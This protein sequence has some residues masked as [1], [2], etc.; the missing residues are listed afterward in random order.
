MSAEMLV[1]GA[2]EGD[3]TSDG[4]DGNGAGESVPMKSTS[5]ASD[6]PPSAPVGGAAHAAKPAR[7]GVKVDMDSHGGLRGIASVVIMMQH[8]LGETRYRLDSNGSSMLPL[9][10]MLS[11]FSMAV[12][13]G[14]KPLARNRLYAAHFPDASRASPS[15]S[16]SSSSSEDGACTI[17][18]T[19]VSADKMQTIDAISFYQNR[20]ARV[21]PTY[22]LCAAITAPVAYLGCLSWETDNIKG[23][24]G[25]TIMAAVP[26]ASILN[27]FWEIPINGPG[28]TVQTLLYFWLLTPVWLPEAQ[29]LSNA[30]LVRSITRW[31]YVQL[32]L[33]F[34]LYPVWK[35]I[36]DAGQFGA[37]GVSTMSPLSRFPLFLMGIDA[38]MLCQRYAAPGSESEAESLLHAW[39]NKFAFLGN[40]LPSSAHM[41]SPS[42]AET[43]QASDADEEQGTTKTSTAPSAA[44]VGAATINS[45]GNGN[46]DV[47]ASHERLWGSL[48]DAGGLTVFM[49]WFLVTV[50]SR[51]VSW[52]GLARTGDSPTSRSFAYIYI[53]IYI[54]IV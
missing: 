51:R 22:Y 44:K 48:A 19:R 1:K 50:R 21:M 29:R 23:L 35:M 47:S 31:Y 5:S 17:H 46:E 14:R 32:V 36:P 30:Q 53:H 52:P 13:Y 3:G 16:S 4:N 41:A 2:V 43:S 10:F 54:Y 26:V 39:P 7:S 37:I 20:I 42:A 45:N 9:F 40:W 15:S 11:G 27:F 24:L 28:W 18:N 12:V 38:G 25:A 6:A 8:V 34:I 49:S 33:V